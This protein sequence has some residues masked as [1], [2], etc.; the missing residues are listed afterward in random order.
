MFLALAAQKNYY[1][2]YLMHVYQD[3]ENYKQLE[4]AFE[5]MDKKM[6]MG[7]SCLRF[8]STEEI[9]LDEIGEIIGSMTVAD[10]LELF[11]TNYNSKKE[12]KWI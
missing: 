10:Y 11:E 1:S 8:K 3:S 5:R 2:L 7:K 9:P 4:Q 12:T 6:N